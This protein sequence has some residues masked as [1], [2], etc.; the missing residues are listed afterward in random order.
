[1]ANATNMSFMF[2]GC[3]SFNSDLSR[4]NVA[5]ATDL[6]FM[7]HDCTSFN[8]DLSRWNV[9]NATNLSGMFNDCTSFNSD[10]SEWEV[11]NAVSSMFV[12]FYGCG[13]LDRTFLAA[14]PVPNELRVH[15][16]YND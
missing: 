4:W 6:A 5:N 13:S 12:M 8:A 2:E 11:A 15:L 1:V 3:T 7:F 10:L 16:L 9:V 14:W